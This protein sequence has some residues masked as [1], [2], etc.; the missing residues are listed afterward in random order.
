[1]SRNIG[2]TSSSLFQLLP[3]TATWSL[4]FTLYSLL[5][6]GRVVKIRV[7]NEQ[8]SGDRLQSIP[9]SSSSASL[10][11]DP[12]HQCISAHRN[13][14][15]NV[16]YALILAG[17]AEINGA[18]KKYPSMAMATLF[19]LRIAHSEA[20]LLGKDAIANGRPV[21]YFGTQAWLAGVAAY[22]AYLVR[23]YWGY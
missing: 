12:L 16:P 13:F 4:P 1:M 2:L 3:V 18:D 19:A 20:G 15:E 6:S 11:S 14:L 22:S 7:D 10:Q 9:I 5:L 21:G 8:W 17:L 23:G